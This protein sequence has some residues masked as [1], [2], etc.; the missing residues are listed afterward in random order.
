MKFSSLKIHLERGLGSVLRASTNKAHLDILENVHIICVDG[1]ITFEATN[2]DIAVRAKVR[3]SVEQEGEYTVPAKLF[4]DFIQLLPDE[5]VDIDLHD[6]GLQI[7]C[8]NSKT[9]LKGQPAEDFPVIPAKTGES[10]A[11]ISIAEFRQVI[12]RT[13][14]A[15]SAN[16]ARPILAGVSISLHDA[17]LGEGKAIVAA[18]D[19]YR[20]AETVMTISGGGPE[21]IIIP[22][23]TLTELLRI[24]S[25]YKDD[26]EAEHSIKMQYGGEQLFFFYED[27]EMSSRHIAGSYPNYRGIIPKS[28]TAKVRVKKQELHHAIKATSLFSKTGL[29][30]VELNI[31]EESQELVVKS[32]SGMK[33]SHAMPLE[34]Q[35]Q[36]G[37]TDI[38][39]NYRYLLDGLN[40]L[41]SEHVILEL[42]DEKSPVLMKPDEGLDEP[43]LYIVM[44]IRR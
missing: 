27:I 29:F 5:R 23:E 19:G 12:E 16:Q 38:V 17:S 42:T 43:F 9:K 34:A 11:S 1:G 15:A 21:T 10:V 26:A 36:G 14:F 20:L 8:K 31:V 24:L 32:G 33:G 44:P 39:L 40:A 30:D 3:G 6:D 18:M 41:N 25:Y 2:L 13:V 7:V 28:A 4:Y 37:G 35:V 22:R